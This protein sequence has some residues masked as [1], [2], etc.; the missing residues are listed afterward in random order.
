M[1]EREGDLGPL[2][3]RNRCS[4]VSGGGRPCSKAQQLL[5]QIVYPEQLRLGRR[6]SSSMAFRSEGSFPC[7]KKALRG[8]AATVPCQRR[9]GGRTSAPRPFAH[10][11]RE[12]SINSTLIVSSPVMS[13]DV[14]KKS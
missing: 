14:W 11:I 1:E 8:R 10:Y 4:S 12:A 2:R 7:D 5:E 6:L 3:V 9:I 13:T